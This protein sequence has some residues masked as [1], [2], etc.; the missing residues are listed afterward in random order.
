MF[1][2]EAMSVEFEPPP[3]GSLMQPVRPTAARRREDA[4]ARVRRDAREDIFSPT[5]RLVNHIRLVDL[6]VKK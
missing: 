6:R 2:I 4:A 5:V 3:P 1:F